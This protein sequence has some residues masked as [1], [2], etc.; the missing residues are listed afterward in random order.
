VV[1]SQD[2]YMHYLN[3]LEKTPAKLVQMTAQLNSELLTTR[4][5]NKWSINENIGHLLTI[6]SLWIAR[7]DDFVMKK[8][9]LRPWNGTNADTEAGEFN[10]QRTMKIIEDFMDVRN[11]HIQMLKNLY[12]KSEEL[13]SFHEDKQKQIS[14]AEHV[15]MMEEHDQLHLTTIENC[16]QAL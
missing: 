9:T 2:Q 14:L 3:Q 11:V 6:E 15:E 4:R 7:L 13:K 10:K 12:S 16:I 5:N 1:V 8:P